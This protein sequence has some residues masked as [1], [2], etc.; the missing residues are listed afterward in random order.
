MLLAIVWYIFGLFVV[1]FGFLGYK[2]QPGTKPIANTNWTV[3]DF[4]NATVSG[5]FQI[6]QG[7]RIFFVE[8]IGGGGKGSGSVGI[9]GVLF[10]VFALV[11]IVF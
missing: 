9:W 1:L 6:C 8:V 11:L 10:G 3:F 2:R 4:G 7:P 5:E